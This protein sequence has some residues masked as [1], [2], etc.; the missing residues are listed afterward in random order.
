[1]SGT[2]AISQSVTL[3]A[4]CYWGTEKYVKKD[5]QNK[6]PNS[7]K[8]ASVG[9]MSPDPNT[10]L[11][12]PTYNQVCSGETGFVEVLQVELNDAETNFEELIKFFFQFHDPT[13]E[14]RQVN[15]AGT[16][17]ASVIFVFDDEQERIVTNIISQL[18]SDLDKSKKNPYEFDKIATKV[19]KATEFHPA[20]EAHQEYL[21]KNPTG[22]CNHRFRFKDWPLN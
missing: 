16:Q 19:W 3:G 22:Y 1:M 17:Y 11:T 2:V 10:A 18:Q 4:G 6:F 12:S 20:H 9:F 8:S 14:D 7:V 15:D 21:M 13:T 5:F